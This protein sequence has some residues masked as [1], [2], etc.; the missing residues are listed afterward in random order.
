MALNQA[1]KLVAKMAIFTRV[2]DHNKALVVYVL[3]PN[4]LLGLM[5]LYIHSHF[6]FVLHNGNHT[7]DISGGVIWVCEHV[8]HKPSCRNVDNDVDEIRNK[9]C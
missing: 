8:H 3:N 5:E 7:G 1:L 4:L 2:S 9:C 6:I